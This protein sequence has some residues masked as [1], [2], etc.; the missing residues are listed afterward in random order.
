MRPRIRQQDRRKA[1]EEF[2]RVTGRAIGRPEDAADTV[3]DVPWPGCCRELE[4]V[5]ASLPFVRAAVALCPWL[6][7]AGAADAF[8]P[9]GPLER[10]Q[11]EAWRFLRE[12][13]PRADLPARPPAGLNASR[14]RAL[15]M[16]RRVRGKGAEREFW[17]GLIRAGGPGIVGA[18]EAPPVEFC[19]AL[20]A[21]LGAQAPE[22]CRHRPADPKTRARMALV[23]MFENVTRATNGRELTPRDVALLVV[24]LG[25]D[26]GPFDEVAQ[27]AKRVYGLRRQAVAFLSGRGFEPA[28]ENRPG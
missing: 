12:A 21:I 22:A 25:L 6:R 8:P 18:S 15:L 17:R 9:L 11:A 3:F 28:I 26:F 10:L 5:F 24:A 16:P 19:R 23:C 4:A 2:E 7:F 1:A 14:V 20:A 27:L 13:S